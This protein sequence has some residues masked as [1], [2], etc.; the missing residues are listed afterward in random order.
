MRK[1]ANILED[2]AVS[3][4]SM[5]D[6]DILSLIDIVREGIKFPAFIH[7]ANKSPFSLQEW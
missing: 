1:I 3:Y 7:F 4:S 2:P 6:K 5:D